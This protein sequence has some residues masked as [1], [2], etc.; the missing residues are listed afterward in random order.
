[1]V[2]GK[3]DNHSKSMKLDL[4]LKPSTKVSSKWIKDLSI[5]PE[6][7][8]LLEENIGSKLLDMGLGND[9]FVFDTKSKGNKRKTNG[10]T[11]K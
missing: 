4:Y 3:P 1:M 7:I 9:F 11:S 6:T 2:L 5:R 8:K 10:A